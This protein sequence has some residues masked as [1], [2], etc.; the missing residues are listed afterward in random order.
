MQT[1][2]DF[3][4]HGQHPDTA[5]ALKAMTI[6]MS[7]VLTEKAEGSPSSSRAVPL[8]THKQYATGKVYR[9]L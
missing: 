7:S 6:T 3:C 2:G 1:S 9:K 4:P 8:D 5:P